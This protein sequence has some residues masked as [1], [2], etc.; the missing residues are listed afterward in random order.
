M[1]ACWFGVDRSTITRAIGEVRPL[2]ARRPLHRR[3]RP[4]AAAG[5]WRWPPRWTW[6][7]HRR[8]QDLTTFPGVRRDCCR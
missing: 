7:S 5:C 2:L 1:L 4:A 6:G 3:A 8:T